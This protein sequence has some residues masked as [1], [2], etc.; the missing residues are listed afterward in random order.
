MGDGSDYRVVGSVF[1]NTSSHNSDQDMEQQITKVNMR[2]APSNRGFLVFKPV[3]LMPFLLF[4]PSTSLP[5][6]QYPRQTLA[7]IPDTD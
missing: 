6:L 7:L 2:K 1:R 4:H 3:C 5:M